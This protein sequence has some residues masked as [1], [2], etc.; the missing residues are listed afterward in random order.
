MAEFPTKSPGEVVTAADWNQIEDYVEARGW[1]PIDSGALSSNTGAIAVPIES[2][3]QHIR[4]TVIGRTTEV[5]RVGLRVNQDST[6]GL[7]V[8][9]LHGRPASGS[10]TKSGDATTSYNVAEWGTVF[11]NRLTFE[12][13]VSGS[14]RCP[15]TATAVR[16][17]SSDTSR[18]RWDSDGYLASPRTPTSVSVL[19]IGPG[20]EFIAGSVESGTRWWLE[21]YRDPT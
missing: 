1:R 12:M 2:G 16:Q 18:I 4:L 11:G 6:S 9:G 15:F 19:A 13:A 3:L 21:G 7:H 5:G 8:W 14:Q 20:N 10:D 17:S